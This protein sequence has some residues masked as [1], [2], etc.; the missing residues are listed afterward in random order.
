MKKFI[1]FV[2][3]G[4]FVQFSQAQNSIEIKKWMLSNS[5]EI[6]L[7]AFADVKNIDGNTFEVS[8]L[9]STT[10]LDPTNKNIEWNTINLGADSIVF[11]QSTAH[12]L[13]ILQTN[14]SVNRWTEGTLNLTLIHFTKFI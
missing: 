2:L 3:L 7:P 10:Q 14:L 9:L 5:P 6:K 12:N 8:N 1:I 11:L 4:I 13:F